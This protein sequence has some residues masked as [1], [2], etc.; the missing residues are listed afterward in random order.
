VLNYTG[1]CIYDLSGRKVTALVNEI[2][3]PDSYV[4]EWNAE[5]V[6]PGIY[7]CELKTDQGRQVMKMFLVK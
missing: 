5:S 2:Q 6:N 1:V 7:F 4:V 3:Q